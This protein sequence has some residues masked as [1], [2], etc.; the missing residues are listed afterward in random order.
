[1]V[2]A[3]GVVCA[4][5]PQRSWF[6]SA[7]KMGGLTGPLASTY[8]CSCHPIPF[9]IWYTRGRLTPGALR[10]SG[11]MLRP[12]AKADDTSSQPCKSRQRRPGRKRHHQLSL[13]LGLHLPP[14]LSSLSKQSCQGVAWPA[15]PPP[16]P[17]E[18]HLD[19]V[20]LATRESKS[21]VLL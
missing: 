9:T 4:V 7:H 2:R 12:D 3:G 19:H 21:T 18:L 5:L 6:C 10:D 14:P 16:G 15:L 1:M 17:L 8:S 13:G 11:S 20:Q